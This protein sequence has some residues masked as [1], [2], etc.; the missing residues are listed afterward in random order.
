MIVFAGICPHTPLVTEVV[1]KDHQETLKKTQEGIRALAV[2]LR[3]ARPETIIILSAH[4]IPHTKAFSANI[5]QTFNVDL[6]LFG[7]LGTQKTFVPNL[8]L[9]DALQR[10]ARR[11]HVPF[12]LDSHE[13]LDY[14]AG[15]PLYLL[16]KELV[17]IKILP[18]TFSSG[19]DIKEHVAFGRLLKEVATSTGTRI[20]IIASGDL[21]HCLSKEAPLGELPEGPIFDAA[22]Q[23]AVR[24]VTA[25]H[26]LS[27]PPLLTHTVG[28]CAL[29]PISMLFGA[30]ERIPLTPTIHSY[31]HPLGV[32]YLVAS[33]TLNEGS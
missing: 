17:G 12:T 14:S 11:Q 29:R 18:V 2:A 8:A 16:T 9:A 26:L 4:G 19:L 33:F 32:G 1:G 25:S 13:L 10:H 24:G 31:E 15:V 30:V 5:H 23:E 27:L 3:A 28:E 6:S 22:I 20:A 7:D 21:A